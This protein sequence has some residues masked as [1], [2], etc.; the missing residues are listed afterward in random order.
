MT[1]AGKFR[2]RSFLNIECPNARNGI[3]DCSAG[4]AGGVFAAGRPR[5]LCDDNCDTS[6]AMTREELEKRMDELA[7]LYR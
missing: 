1:S 7:R 2:T 5:L 3:E 4:M 6:Q